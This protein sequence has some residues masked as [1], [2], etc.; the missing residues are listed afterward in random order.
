MHR[1]SLSPLRTKVILAP[2]PR[3]EMCDV[4]SSCISLVVVNIDR[5]DADPYLDHHTSGLKGGID[6]LQIS[7]FAR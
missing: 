4:H 1:F 6:G 2:H 3:C 7:A 5:H